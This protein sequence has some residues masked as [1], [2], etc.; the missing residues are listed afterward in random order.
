MKLI[1]HSL[2]GCLLVLGAVAGSIGFTPKPART[3]V[4][5]NNKLFE[6]VEV[7]K[8]EIPPVIIIDKRPDDRPK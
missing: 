4:I 7:K 3:V 2:N 8:E 6:P 1:Y 5:D